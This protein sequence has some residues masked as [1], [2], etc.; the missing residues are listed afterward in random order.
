MWKNIHVCHPQLNDPHMYL[1]H[2]QSQNLLRWWLSAIMRFMIG[3]WYFLFPENGLLPVSSFTLIFMLLC[4]HIT[5]KVWIFWDQQF[6]SREIALPI[7]TSNLSQHRQKADQWTYPMFPTMRLKPSYSWA[8]CSTAWQKSKLDSATP[9][10]KSDTKPPI[11][12]ENK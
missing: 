1:F 5:N 7:F 3:T 11:G 8:C 12:H 2:S 10:R 6:L 4:S 9:N